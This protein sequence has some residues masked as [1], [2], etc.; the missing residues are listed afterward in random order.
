[1][2][3]LSFIFRSIALVLCFS[4]GLPNP[5]LALRVRSG[6][7]EEHTPVTDALDAVLHQPFTFRS[8]GLPF[9]AG[10]EER[11]KSSDGPFVFW[12]GAVSAALLGLALVATNHWIRPPDP[13]PP[14]QKVA[15]PE[16]RPCG[17][18]RFG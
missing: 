18:G 13:L 4:L 9:S 17:R 16:A 5:A 12:V 3:K 2:K 1:M 7:L 6:G 8:V 14:A 15:P 11:K 10:V